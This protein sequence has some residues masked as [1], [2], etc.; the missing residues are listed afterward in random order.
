MLHPAILLRHAF[1]V[2]LHRSK[3][4]I[5]IQYRAI[6]PIR[7]RL[8]R[9]RQFRNGTSRESL[10]LFDDTFDLFVTNVDRGHFLGPSAGWVEE[11]FFNVLGNHF[12]TF[13]FSWQVKL[14]HFV[15]TI[16]YSSVELRRL[17][18]GIYHHK[19]IALRTSSV[20]KG[21]QR[22]PL[23]FRDLGRFTTLEKSIRLIHKQ[24]QSLSTRLRPLKQFVNFR[25]RIAPQRCNITTSQNRKFQSRMLCQAFCKHRLTRS[26]WAVQQK[27]TERSPIL[28][29][30]C[31]RHGN[32]T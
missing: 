25:H 6:R 20:Q 19:L 3:E 27:V 4:R 30:V 23:I 7:C 9:N 17:V 18:T 26:G 31:S 24:K 21:I 10:S 32:F 5:L 12:P 1:L 29:R 15:N 11:V 16:Q 8:P 28:F 14:Y 13:V 22:I 2:V